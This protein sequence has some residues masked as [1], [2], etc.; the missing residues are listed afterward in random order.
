MYT[1][2]KPFTIVLLGLLRIFQSHCTRT[3]H[4]TVYR[5]IS[6]QRSTQLKL[7]LVRFQNLF[8]QPTRSEGREIY[9]VEEQCD[10]PVGMEEKEPEGG[11]VGGSQSGA[12]RR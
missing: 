12:I 7:T 10:K 9:L 4:L 11:S 6:I 3:V 1:Q 2:L 5:T 8:H